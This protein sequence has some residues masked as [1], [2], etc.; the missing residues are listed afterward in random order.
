MLCSRAGAY[1]NGNIID[2][3]GGRSLVLHCLVLS[4]ILL[5]GLTEFRDRWLVAQSSPQH[6]RHSTV[7]QTGAAEQ[8]KHTRGTDRDFGAKEPK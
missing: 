1:T 6:R 2:I 4:G 5:L 7:V 3:S 8:Q